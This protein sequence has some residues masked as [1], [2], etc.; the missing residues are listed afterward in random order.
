LGSRMI[1]PI[2]FHFRHRGSLLCP[3]RKVVFVLPM[4]AAAPSTRRGIHGQDI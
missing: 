3:Y 1:G 2:G 4:G